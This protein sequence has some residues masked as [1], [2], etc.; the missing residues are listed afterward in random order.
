LLPE[1]L[2]IASLDLEGFGREVGE[3]GR[4]LEREQGEA[5]VE[6][7]HKMVLWSDICAAVG[8]ATMWMEP[9]IVSVVALSLWTHSRW[10]MI[11][12]H[13]SHGG[14]NRTDA[15][16]RYSSRGFA[17]GTLWRRV[18][19]WFDW[20]LPEAWGVE[21]NQLHHYRLGE[22]ADPDLVE[23]NILAWGGLNKDFMTF[24]SM[25]V[26]KWY[27]Y[28]P[29]TY[30]ELKVAE[31]RRSG[32]PLPEG[33][34]PQ[35]P[36]TLIDAV[37]GTF[38]GT[39]APYSLLDLLLNV[40]GPYFLGRFVLLPLPLALLSPAFFWHA[41]ANLILAELLSN[42]HDFAVITTNHAGEDLYRFER[43]CKPRSPTFFLR[44]VVSSTNF[45]TGGDVN[46]FLHGWLNYQI[47]HHVWPNLS[48]L[49]YQRGQPELQAICQK[50]GVPYVQEDILTR[51]RKTIDIFTGRSAMRQY[52]DHLERAED[53]MLWSD[54][55]E[56]QKQAARRAP[57]P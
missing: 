31:L 4:R 46:D 40:I 5:D 28:A 13:C 37:L 55:K 36:F 27:Y 53:M 45:A 16:G 29:N 14:Y 42:V 18:V 2:W 39:P 6:H 19:D 50:Y 49:S 8:L 15:S 17:I 20:M 44:A 54:E 10:T 51:L 12:H 56:L 47:E 48:M 1:D 26:W 21:H 11:G 57:A 41:C 43:G 9:N 22:D 34:D 38:G 23:R 33:F 7:L 25:F 30:K 52:P 24:V 3:L 35:R 32:Q